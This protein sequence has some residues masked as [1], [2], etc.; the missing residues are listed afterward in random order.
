M[1]ECNDEKADVALVKRGRVGPGQ[2]PL[3]PHLETIRSMR[4]ARKSWSSI[5]LYLEEAHDLKT[6]ESSI[7]RFF[8]RAAMSGTSPG[9]EDNAGAVQGEAP[10]ER[11]ENPRVMIVG[12]A[13]N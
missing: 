5:A 10:I 1:S 6:S 11:V 8:Q 12:S 13:S 3:W 7:R 2:S 9:E 4:R